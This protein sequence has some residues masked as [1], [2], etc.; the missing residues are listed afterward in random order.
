MIKRIKK[1]IKKI[2]KAYI[3]GMAEVYKPF[4]DNRVNPFI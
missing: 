1:T 2:G 4:I 3:D